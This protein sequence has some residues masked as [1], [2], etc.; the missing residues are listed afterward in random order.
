M[1]LAVATPDLEG[2]S[3]HLAKREAVIVL[4]NAE[5]LVDVVAVAAEVL[6]RSCP[7]VRLLVISREPLGVEGEWT[8]ES[9]RWPNRTLSGCSSTEP[10]KRRP[11]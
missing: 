7:H 8:T 4:D 5:H 6:A 3:G 1:V 10:G 2:L 11:R 9:A